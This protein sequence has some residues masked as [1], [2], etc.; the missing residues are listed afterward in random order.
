MHSC[1]KWIYSLLI[2]MQGSWEKKLI[3]RA[4]NA[5]KPGRKRQAEMSDTSVPPSK[6]GR[7]RKDVLLE[8]YPELVLLRIHRRQ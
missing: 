4:N 3:E 1:Y 2:G 5:A 8:K 6:R 7:P